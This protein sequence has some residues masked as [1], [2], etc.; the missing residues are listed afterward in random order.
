MTQLLNNIYDFLVEHDFPTLLE[1]LRKLE[2]NMIAQKRL[3]LAYHPADS[4][5][6]GLDEK[7]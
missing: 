7:I 2:W 1:S 5:L 6:P 3:Y 4:D